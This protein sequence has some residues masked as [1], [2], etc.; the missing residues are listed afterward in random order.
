M[1]RHGNLSHRGEVGQQHRQCRLDLI[2]QGR[3]LVRC[4]G[5]VRQ[6][7]PP[8]RIVGVQLPGDTGQ[9]PRPGPDGVGGGELT[10]QQRAAV[11]DQ[12]AG[13]I[14]GPLEVGG[15]PRRRLRQRAQIV[16]G[17]VKRLEGLVEQVGYPFL[18]N[19]L[20]QGVHP[21][22]HRADR[23]R[24]RGVLRRDHRAVLQV[25]PG[26]GLRHQ[27]HV[28]LADRRHTEYPGLQVGGHLR[29]GG[30]RQGGLRTALGRTHV[31]DLAQ[32]DA[33]VG[34]VRELIEP[35]GSR[36]LQLDRH[37]ADAEQRRNLHV[38]DHHDRDT[39]DR[40]DGE[41]DQ[42]I[43]NESGQH[44]LPPPP[45]GSDAGSGPGSG[46]PGKGPGGGGPGRGP[47]P[48]PAAGW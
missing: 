14:G 36:Q 42:L 22:E 2:E 32:L 6:D 1:I 48:M 33:P 17:A 7:G 3:G 35:T 18:R 39:D 25:G 15:Q 23:L 38:G 20:Q 29:R 46:G 10:V 4:A 31:G 27:V 43:T 13:L 24:N 30:Q 45:W 28:L 5:P 40:G 41:D 21:V 37:A 44:Q 19:A 26:V 11:L 12:R 16:R 47:G 8:L 34:D 9:A